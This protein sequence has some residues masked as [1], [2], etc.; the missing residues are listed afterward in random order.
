MGAFLGF[1]VWNSDIRSRLHHWRG[2]N[3]G[4]VVNKHP[5]FPM[6]KLLGIDW[7]YFFENPMDGGDFKKFGA[8]VGLYDWG[9]AETQS[10]INHSGRVE[11][12]RS[13]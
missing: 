1:K 6:S 13:T 5:W 8:G 2:F 4:T 11:P 7:D 10:L 9:H 3:V 12:L